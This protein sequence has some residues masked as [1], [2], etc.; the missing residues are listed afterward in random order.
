MEMT[1]RENIPPDVTEAQ[2]ERAPVSLSPQPSTPSPGVE[3]EGRRARARGG[4]ECGTGQKSVR[5]CTGASTRH[6]VRQEHGAEDAVVT[7][8]QYGAKTATK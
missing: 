2:G 7:S 3:R 8:R 4:G 5:R 6:S 1:E